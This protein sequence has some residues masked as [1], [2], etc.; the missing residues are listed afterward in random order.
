MPSELFRTVSTR[1]LALVVWLCGTSCFLV[2]QDKPE[3]PRIALAAP[4]VLVPNSTMK[5]VVRGWKLNREITAKTPLADVQIKVLRHDN[6]A[7]PNGQDVKQIGD[8][9]VELEVTVPA[10]DS[11]ATVP[12]T[13]LADSL[14][15]KPYELLVGGPHPVVAEAEPNDGFRQA[16]AVAV[17][18]IVDGQIHADRNVD[19]YAVTLASPQTLRMEVLARRQ[20]SGLD[21]LLTVIDS[22]GRIVAMNDDADGADSRLELPLPAGRYFL[23][24]QDASDH[25]GPAHPYRF[26]VQPAPR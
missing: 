14:E 3:P 21:S 8:S 1:L 10:R 17:P 19:V 26:I 5:V 9:L 12:F 16:Q 24:V 15:S 2:A 7:A 11:A 20:G 25:G 13:L 6:A 23:V 18:Q 4:F 22:Q